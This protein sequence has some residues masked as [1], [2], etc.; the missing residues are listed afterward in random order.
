MHKV[1]FTDVDK[2]ISQIM[3]TSKPG[4]M[5]AFSFQFF[6]ICAFVSDFTFFPIRSQTCATKSP[7]ISPTCSGD[8]LSLAEVRCK[9]LGLFDV[10]GEDSFF[11]PCFSVL[12]PSAAY[13][14]CVYD[15]C[16]DET[17][18]VCE[19]MKNYGDSCTTLGA[20]IH[21]R[22]MMS[23]LCGETRKLF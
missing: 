11:S 1:Q 4:R 19:I 23:G 20:P 16:L 5:L 7:P 17:R 21:W 2:Y 6:W 13:D 9:P 8:R 22:E 12:D 15:V 10:T 14:D 18:D 3:Y